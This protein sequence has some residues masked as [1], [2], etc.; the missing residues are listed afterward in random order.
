MAARFTV[1]DDPTEIVQFS[2][3]DQEGKLTKS[4]LRSAC[5][6]PY[7]AKY[8][9]NG[10]ISLICLVVF[11]LWNYGIIPGTKMGFYCNDPL[12]SHKY[13]GDTVTSLA[14]W[15]GLTLI[16][17]ALYYVIEIT[18]QNN[19]K[20][21]FTMES[22]TEFYVYL[23]NYTIG[24][25]LSEGLTEIAKTIV[26]EHR[27]HFFDTCRPDTNINCTVGEYIIDFTCTRTDLP[28][29]DLVDA[30]RSFPSGH[31]SGAWCGALFCAY[32]IHSRLPIHKTGTALKLFMFALSM[33]FGLAC[34]LTRITDRRHHWWDVLT[35]SI[36]GM[37]GAA[38]VIALTRRQVRLLRKKLSD[39]ESDRKNKTEYIGV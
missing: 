21:L 6:P 27:P 23:K 20:R 22:F 32:I 17:P 36:V 12:F 8:Y 7:P 11:L 34:S 39:E 2:F 25:I 31:S 37:L 18:R 19:C 28:Y 10:V 26:G 4:S 14:L 3:L 30:S 33:T 5:L 35:G 24:L 16:V 15:L 29:L 38:F 1:D 13:R 9:A